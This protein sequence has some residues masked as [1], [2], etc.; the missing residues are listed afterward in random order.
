MKI[1]TFGYWFFDELAPLIGLGKPHFNIDTP[2][3]GCFYIKASSLRLECLVRN[4]TCVK[5]GREGAL[6]LLQAHHCWTDDD[7]NI[8]L[9]ETPHLNL[10]AVNDN[11][12]LV[13]MTRDHIIPRSK[14][15]A[16]ILE[17]LQTLCTICN[18]EKAD[19]L[20]NEHQTCA[21]LLP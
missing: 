11:D 19:K 5:C 3:Y 14:R 10:Y 9:R 4:N 16:D 13:L 20:P 21:H 15:G 2:N 8:H 6:W 7:G 12:T 1:P 18:A 17:N